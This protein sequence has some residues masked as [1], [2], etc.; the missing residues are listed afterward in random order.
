ML[1]AKEAYLRWHCRMILAHLPRMIA[2]SAVKRREIIFLPNIKACGRHV[3]GHLARTLAA[4]ILIIAL[5]AG[6]AHASSGNCDWQALILKGAQLPTLVGS[7]ES[8]FEVL[9]IRDGNLKPIPF[10]VDEVLPDGSWA[11]PDGPEPSA[12][13]RPGILGKDDEVVMMISDLGARAKTGSA[14]M[15]PGALEIETN[16]PLTAEHRYAYIADVPLPWLSH[17]RYVNY[18]PK[19]RR[20]E[21][22]F[23][24]VSFSN[25][26][27]TELAIQDRMFED[28]PSLVAGAQVHAS[29]KV[30]T[31]FDLN[32][33]RDDV[34]NRLLAW[35]AGPVRI[36]RRLSH[37]VSLILGIQ[38]PRVVSEEFFYRDYVEEPFKATVVWV[39]RVLFGNV[40]VR[41]YVDF[42]RLHDF[43]LAWSGMSGLP[44]KIGDPAS[45]R[46]IEMRD[47]PPSADWFAL[48]G[49]GKL[50]IQTFRP[51]PDLAVVRPRLYYR[52][53][54][55][56]TLQEPQAPAIGFL[57]TGWQDLSSGTHQLNPLLIVVPDDCSSQ[58]L[59]REIEAQ[60][61]VRVTPIAERRN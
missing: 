18:A 58:S 30:L 27:P 12:D 28:T 53:P 51:S 15:P 10:Q 13:D 5:P 37:S 8:H 57:M 7:S 36:I 9:A 49:Q 20:V 14:G 40:R 11:L 4:S 61:L 22:G 39:P 47:S 1:V 43:T 52:D 24:R 32:I 6:F 17:V 59:F 26:F 25:D 50:M 56:D 42:V 2:T 33:N 46:T 48:R 41:I 23:Y 38:P 54:S 60:P 34:S 3:L 55:P 21:G 19:L 45:E 31:F 44:I 29:A 35:R 16:D